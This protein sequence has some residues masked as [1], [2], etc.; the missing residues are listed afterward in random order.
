MAA[1]RGA[2]RYELGWKPATLPEVDTAAFRDGG[3]YL[4]TG[5]LGGI[6]LSIARDLAEAHTA[7]IVLVSRSTLPPRSEWDSVEA[8]FGASEATRRRV[9]AIREIEA[10]GGT[11][12]VARADI[13]DI[14]QMRRAVDEATTSFGP[15]NGV[16][17]AAGVIDDAPLLGKT[18]QDIETVFAPK[19]HGLRVLD[20]I[21]DDGALDLMILCS[22]TSTITRPE[23]QIDY[24]A[25]N[26][27]L[28]AYAQGRKGGQTR[29]LAVNW[30]VWGT[31]GMAANLIA[32]RQSEGAEA[33]WMP[34]GLPLLSEAARGGRGRL[35]LDDTKWVVDDHRMKDGT[36]VLPGTGFVELALETHIASGGALPV[37]MSD[38]MFLRPLDAAGDQRNVETRLEPDTGTSQRLEIRSA[39]RV[40]GRAGLVLNAQAALRACAEAPAPLDLVA[41]AAR[42]PTPSAHLREGAFVSPQE[43]HLQFGPRW[44]VVQQAHVGDGEGFARLHLPEPHHADL[45]N[46]MILH[47]AMLD[48]ATGW[49]ME[50]IDGYTPDRL[51]VPVLYGRITVY[52]PMPTQI[53]SWVRLRAESDGAAGVAAFDVIIC[54][55]DGAIVAEIADFQMQRLESEAALG[56][57]A[58]TK[59]DDV[60]FEDAVV[61]REPSEAE[62]QMQRM[63]ALGIRPAEGVAALRRALGRAEAQ[64]ALSPLPLDA[65]I[66]LAQPAEKSTAAQSFERPELDADYAAPT[67]VTESALTEIWEKLLGV[68]R[69]GVNDSFFDL[70]GHSLLAVRL[71]AAVKRR[72]G[73]QFP[74]SVLFEAPTIATCATLIDAQTGGGGTAAAK[75][76]AGKPDTL[77]QPAFRYAVALNA[78]KPGRKAPFFIVAGMFGNVLNLRHL[79]LQMDDRAVFGLQARGLIGNEAP[80]DTIE[81]AA[82][83]YIA[84]MRAIQPEG[85]YLIAGFSGGGITAYEIAHQLTEAG[86]EV[87]VLA[88]LDTPVPVRPALKSADK[89]VMKLQDIRR[90][91][92]RYVLEWAANR[93][94]WEMTKRARAQGG[95]VPADEGS[96]NNRQIEMAFRGAVAQYRL[97]PW[98]GPLTLFRPPLDRHWKVT[99]GNWVSRERE[100]VFDDNAWYG[101]ATRLEVVE[102]PGDHDSMVL[103]PNVSVLAKHL[104]R[105]VRETDHAHLRPDA[106]TTRTAAE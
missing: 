59:A 39:C 8:A 98:T 101:W 67:T 89:L 73:V 57:T 25:A 52:R 104:N 36:A 37:E 34:T 31:V 76:D 41:L 66:A 72:F 51:W 43:A 102:V 74:I 69:I 63:V 80:H 87:A 9:K 64:I 95:E 3:T 45:G 77:S 46:G 48:L 23:G 85:P 94:Q 50:L 17:H 97:Q 90:K 44:R 60:Q 49:A 92:P 20:Q 55:A 103:M 71:F 26:A 84:E 7:N 24:V 29:A 58:V 65:L 100:Y 86:Q 96:F 47:P 18:A 1:Y 88:M 12:Q 11:V 42:C 5:G 33:E 81:S 99:G 16:I 27:Y 6:G 2:R 105:L 93:W 68:D 53:F 14:D 35:A 40:D 13:C 15:I 56:N 106:L 21:F 70:G 82:A 54:D 78:T 83:D 28:N 61:A 22:S 62:K 91:G 38:L 19:V 30:G 32:D 79:A 75:E 10:L 4:I